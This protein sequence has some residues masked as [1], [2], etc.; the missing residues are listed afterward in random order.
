MLG[1]L[2]RPG[3]AGWLTLATAVIAI[4]AAMVALSRSAALTSG[5]PPVVSPQR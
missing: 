1:E 5:D 4:I 3:R 2:L